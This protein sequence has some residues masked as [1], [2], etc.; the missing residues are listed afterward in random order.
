MVLLL[1]V[2]GCQFLRHNGPLIGMFDTKHG[3]Q[4]GYVYDAASIS[5]QIQTSFVQIMVCCYYGFIA[6]S[7]SNNDGQKVWYLSH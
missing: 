5:Q 3:Q 1:M 7:Q 4:D 6:P 2:F